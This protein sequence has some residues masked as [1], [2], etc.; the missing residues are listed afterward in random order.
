MSEAVQE[1]IIGLLRGLV[2]GTAVLLL[3]VMVRQVVERFSP[4]PEVEAVSQDV[5][6][7]VVLPDFAAID[8]VDEKKDAFFSFL[9]EYVEA[10]NH[11]IRDQREVA[12]TLYDIL[13]RGMDLSRLELKDLQQLAADYRIDMANLTPE[14]VARELVLRVDTL[15]TSLVLAQ[16]ANESAWGSSRFAKEGNNI[17]G[18]WCFDEGCGLVPERR[19]ADAE[20]EVR[21]FASVEAAVRSYFRNINTNVAYSSLREMRRDMRGQGRPLDAVVLA[22]GLI[23]YSE[24]GHHYVNELHDIIRQNSLQRLDHS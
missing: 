23:Q 3:F 15:P 9:I 6:S 11:R 5:S 12:V 18:Q 10:E 16:A 4:V 22:H 24:R 20:H 21:A 2:V 13:R 19:S 17:F 14:E 8:N 7:T 1:R